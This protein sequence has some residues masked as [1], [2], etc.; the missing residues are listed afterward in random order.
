MRLNRFGFLVALGACG[1]DQELPGFGQ[2]LGD[3]GAVQ[4]SE[5][6]S[7]K[8]PP[9]SEVSD[10]DALEFSLGL[11]ETFFDNSE[12]SFEEWR[13]FWAD[14]IHLIFQGTSLPLAAFNYDG[15]HP[16]GRDYTDYDLDDYLSVYSPRA[17]HWPALVEEYPEL[18]ESLNTLLSVGADDW[19]FLGSEIQEGEQG[20]LWEDYLVFGVT[21]SEEKG[22]KA[23]FLL[24]Q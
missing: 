9:L 13:S 19:V 17:V 2:G 18:E 4:D 6:P 8:H 7:E 16:F 1:G 12:E 22:W 14:P 20:F 10:A 21:Y 23:S 3:T 24:H 11:V 15:S 5:E